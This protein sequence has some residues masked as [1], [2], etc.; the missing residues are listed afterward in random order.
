MQV[1]LY[2][3]RIVVDAERQIGR[4]R[5]VEEEALDIGTSRLSQG[6]SALSALV[7]IERWTGADLPVRV[8]A[9]PLL[10]AG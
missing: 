9:E 4:I 1:A 7:E 10:A 3:R 2:P 6:S 8:L 5:D